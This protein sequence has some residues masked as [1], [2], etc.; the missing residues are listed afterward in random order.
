MPVGFQLDEDGEL[1]PQPGAVQLGPVAGDL[2]L[3]RAQASQ[4]RGR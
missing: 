4:A 3:E 2:L 1:Q